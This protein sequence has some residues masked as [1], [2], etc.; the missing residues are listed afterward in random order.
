MEPKED[1]RR[2]C[3]TV[4]MKANL[5]NYESADASI[6]LSGLEPGM[7]EAQIGELLDTTHVAFKLIKTRL[8][9]KVGELRDE[10]N[11]RTY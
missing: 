2:A 1:T 5:G 10:R 8:L 3:V 11:G 4:G 6:C 7:S 9:A